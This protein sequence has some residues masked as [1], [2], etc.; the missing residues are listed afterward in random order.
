PSGRRTRRRP[1]P[2]QAR[3]RERA[4]T[5]P[6]ERIDMTRLDLHERL[7]HLIDPD[8]EFELLGQGY[9]FSEGPAW[10]DHTEELIFHDI[11]GDARWRWTEARGVEL[12]ESPN[13]KGNGAV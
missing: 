2:S 5:R 7:H 13:F 3:P 4:A 6:K 9:V 11:P 1:A 8:A 10:N 12:V